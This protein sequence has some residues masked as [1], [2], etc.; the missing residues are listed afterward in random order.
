[1]ANPQREDLEKHIKML[2][3]AIAF[4]KRNG[5][6]YM[7]VKELKEAELILQR[8]RKRFKIYGELLALDQPTV[9][10]IKSYSNP[11]ELV[12]KVMMGVFIMLGHKESDMKVSLTKN[13]LFSS[14]TRQKQNQ[15]I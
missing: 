5:F 7:F 13:C 14:S 11:P 4:I 9:A 8:L 6:E 12:H 1:M 3:G 10:E 2:E 15:N